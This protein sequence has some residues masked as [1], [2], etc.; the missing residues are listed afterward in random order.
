MSLLANPVG[1]TLAT[2][3][4]RPG[5]PNL[6]QSARARDDRVAVWTLQNRTLQ[7]EKIVITQAEA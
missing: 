3:A 1:G 6:P 4:A 2:A 7:S 5:E